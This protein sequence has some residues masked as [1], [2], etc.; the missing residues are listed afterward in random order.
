MIVTE[1]MRDRG[2]LAGVNVGDFLDIPQGG[3]LLLV[4]V[5]ER[6]TAS[7]LDAYVAALGEVMVGSR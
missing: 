6:R 1:A 5:T 4:A 2:I 7:E 3:K